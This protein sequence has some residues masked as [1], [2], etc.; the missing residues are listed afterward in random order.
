MTSRLVRLPEPVY[1][2]LRTE[3]RKKSVSMSSLLALAV[4]QYTG[5]IPTATPAPTDTRIVEVLASW[6]DDDEEDSHD[7]D[8]D[9]E[10]D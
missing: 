1:N 7:D 9:P 3:A 6:P 4:Q 8:Y 5:S 10:D 2:L